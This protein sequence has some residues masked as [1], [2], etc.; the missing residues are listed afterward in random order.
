VLG[1]FIE[2]MIT[3]LISE[4]GKPDKDPNTVKLINSALLRALEL[5]DFNSINHIL[6]ELLVKHKRKQ[7][8]SKIQGLILKC[9]LKV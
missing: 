8:Q 6:V 1:R 2:E 5:S 9:L 3:R 7:K 4:D